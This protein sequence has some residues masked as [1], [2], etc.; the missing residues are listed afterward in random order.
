LNTEKLH[1]EIFLL[2]IYLGALFE[3]VGPSK[4][5]LLTGSMWILP[6]ALVNEEKVKSEIAASIAN[7]PFTKMVKRR[8]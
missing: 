3:E 8:L 2:F 5:D 6:E 4:A 7:L 1:Y